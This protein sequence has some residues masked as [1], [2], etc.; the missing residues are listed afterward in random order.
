M[1]TFHQARMAGKRA[2]LSISEP[3]KLFIE[4]K[5]VSYAQL[6]TVNEH[7]VPQQN[8]SQLAIL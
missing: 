2:V 6:L 8:R 4:G 3:D 7:N 5:P 1:P